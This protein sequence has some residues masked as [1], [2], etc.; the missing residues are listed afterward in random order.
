VKNNKLKH[1]SSEK[2][3]N[4]EEYIERIEW[5]D[6]TYNC[7]ERGLVTQKVKVTRFKPQT[8]PPP[9]NPFDAEMI[10]EILGNE[11]EEI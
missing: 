8:T 6:I 11:D 5:K 4:K 9:S 2:K 1:K 7:P 10:K 3:Q